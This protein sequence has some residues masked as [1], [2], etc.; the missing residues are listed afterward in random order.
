MP[1]VRFRPDLYSAEHV[2]TDLSDLRGRDTAEKVDPMKTLLTV[3]AL[4]LLTIAVRADSIPPAQ[5]PN[6]V[7]INGVNS[8]SGSYNKQG[9]VISGSGQ[10][11]GGGT[12]FFGA[13]GIPK[14]GGKFATGWLSVASPGVSTPGFNLSGALTKI[15]FNPVTGLL[16]ANFQGQ[17]RWSGGVVHIYY[18]TFYE[19]INPKTGS[20]SN[21]HLVYSTAPEPET[22]ALMLTGILGLGLVARRKLGSRTPVEN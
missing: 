17:L 9:N 12:Y 20:L 19:T 2:G 1:K 5:F 13:S 15:W 22:W 8:G 14:F 21:G 18:A 11:Y 7:P 3:A 16:T 10:S 4:A 6:Y